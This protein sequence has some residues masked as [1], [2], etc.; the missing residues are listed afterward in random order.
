ML[1][2]QWDKNKA[3][4]NHNK[5]GVTF[6]EAATVFGDYLSMTFPDF[7]H[8]IDEERYLIIG[9]SEQNRILVVSHTHRIQSIR[10]I[11]AREATKRE[12]QYC[13]SIK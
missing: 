11:S 5:H 2:F 6:D 13:E 8:S 4:S 9:K 7:E 12:R 3:A 1:D 10:I